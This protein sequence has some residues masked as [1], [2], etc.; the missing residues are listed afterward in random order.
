MSD[1]LLTLDEAAAMVRLHRTTLARAIERGELEA[2]RL[3]GRWRIR[4]DAIEAWV[5]ASTPAP[6]VA[7]Q[8][9]RLTHV[10]SSRAPSRGDEAYSFTPKRR[11]KAA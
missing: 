8:R 6:R 3:C 1:G 5:A 10:P 7:P 11:R 9:A 4:P 2:A